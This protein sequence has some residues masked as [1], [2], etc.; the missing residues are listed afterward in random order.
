M[1]TIYRSE[2]RPTKLELLAGWLPGRPW[3]AAPPA[4]QLDAV[5]S[6]RFDDADGEVGI[7]THVLRADDG[8]LLQVPLT[9]RGAPLEGAEGSLVG[10]MEHSVLGR[11]W[12]YDGCSD[13]AWATALATVVLSGG[14]EAEEIVHVEGRREPRRPTVSV[15]GSGTAAGTVPPAGRLTVTEDATRTVVRTAGPELT[16]LRVLDTSAATDGGA[17][18]TGTFAGQ[19]DPV[20]LAWLRQ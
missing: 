11:R 17:V 14:H 7:E 12:V 4:S 9:Y 10:T 1:A 3:Y 18:L 15:R 8:A 16:L 19:D 6:Y 2:V 20:L 13:P 5:G